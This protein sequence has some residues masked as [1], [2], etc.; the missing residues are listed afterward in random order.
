MRKDFYF[1]HDQTLEQVAREVVTILGDTQNL[2][3]HGP[4]QPAPEQGVGL[5]NLQRCP[6]ASAVL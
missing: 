1:K 3:A 2:T 4:G 5:D 6:P